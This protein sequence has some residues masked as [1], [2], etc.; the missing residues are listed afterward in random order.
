M[1]R[2]VEC[3]VFFIGRDD[4]FQRQSGQ[5]PEFAH[6]ASLLNLELDAS[7]GD[8]V[9]HVLQREPPGGHVGDESSA[10]LR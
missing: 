2:W 4:T 6:A 10:D 3:D 1:R 7:F 9:C 5:W 8:V